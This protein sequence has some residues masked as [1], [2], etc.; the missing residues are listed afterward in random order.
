MRRSASQRAASALYSI[1]MRLPRTEFQL[2]RV[3]LL[4]FVLCCLSGF[5]VPGFG[6]SDQDSSSSQKPAAD[7]KP[8][9][10]KAGDKSTD[11]D[12]NALPPLPADAH[13]EQT[14]ELNGKTLHYTVMV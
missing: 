13:A 6:Q 2:M 9:G 7:K 10:E 3:T 5:A 1:V 11:K 12:K 8:D 14:I 4:A